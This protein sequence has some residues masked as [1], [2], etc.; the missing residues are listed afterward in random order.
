MD[1]PPIISGFLLGGWRGVVIQLLIFIASVVIWFPFVKMQD[2]IYVKEELANAEAN[3]E[4]AT[5]A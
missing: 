4:A 2:R 1:Y 5:E 3:A